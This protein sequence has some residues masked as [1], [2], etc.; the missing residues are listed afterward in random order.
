MKFETKLVNLEVKDDYGATNTPIYLNNSFAY[1][2][3]EDLEEVFK[4]QSP[5]Y[6][7]TRIGNP[8]LKAVEDKLA[9]LE[10]GVTG[11]LTASGMAAIST[12][13]LALLEAGDEFVATSS[14]FGGT[15]N[16]FKSYQRFGIKPCF[17]SGIEKDDIAK[18]LSEK[19][20][21]VFLETLGNPGLDIPDI[22]GIAK[23]CKEKEIPLLVDSTMTSPALIKPLELG[24]DIVLHSTSK[25]INGTGSSIGGVIVDGGSFDWTKLS[26][27]EDYEKFK[28]MAFSAKIRG[29]TFRNLGTCQSPIEASL[30]ELGLSTLALRMERHCQNALELAQFLADEPKVKEV[31]YP[32]L[33]DNQ[34]YKRASDLFTGGYGGMLTL[35]VG[36]RENAFKVINNL[37]YFYNLANLG[38]VKSLIIHPASTIYTNNTPKERKMLGVYDDLLRVSVG[39]EN[40]ED[41][42][43]D[44]KKVLSKI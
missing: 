20:K 39:I 27:F 8:S 5:G 23:L 19:T 43:K 1:D 18:E 7:Y 10:G 33:K 38:D 37:D 31:V 11:L 17:A 4:G 14:L 34:Y 35:R 41:L 44:F 24:A 15:Y 3:A 25:Y 28:K 40:I 13:T 12:A 42:K 2:K 6:I 9:S 16:L 36:N 22:K 21:F 30:N 26:G 29:E 32:G